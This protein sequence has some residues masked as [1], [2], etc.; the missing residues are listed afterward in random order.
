MRQ[1][2]QKILFTICILATLPLV[3]VAQ[4]SKA[5]GKGEAIIEKGNMREA[6]KVATESA[7]LD[8]VR[9]YLWNSEEIEDIPDITPEFIKFIKSYK[10]TARSVDGYKVNIGVEASLDA[11]TLKD[12]NQFLNKKLDTAVFVFSPLA[13][14]SPVTN[15]DVSRTIT[16]ILQNKNFSIMEQNKFLYNITNQS[17]N[18]QI[19]NA[20][21]SVN[22][23]YLF[24]I[25]LDVT[26]PDIELSENTCEV[27]MVTDI[28]MKNG[29][30]KVLKVS[31]G[32]PETDKKQ[33]VIDS[34]NQG[35]ASTIDY[36]RDNIIQ[37]QSENAKVYYYEIKAINFTNMIATNKF[38]GSLKQKRFVN[39][40]KAASFASKEII[41]N[42]ESLFDK[43]KLKEKISEAKL[44]K[45]I[46]IETNPKGLVLD[47]TQN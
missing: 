25:N 31:I 46:K 15:N 2:I 1:H 20:F 18:T 45:D 9:E 10:V 28:K 16:Q 33:C 34:I 13:S 44:D 39:S 11:V 14:G 22:A 42:I 37:E 7:L 4:T 17:D 21:G 8:A 26:Y 35:L 27:A 5:I 47:F 24:K 40:Y 29:D 43:D 3:A 19:V 36:I 30:E 32:L 12:A 6:Y 23:K 41:F 38:F